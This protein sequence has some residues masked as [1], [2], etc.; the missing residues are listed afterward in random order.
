MIKKAPFARLVREIM[1]DLNKFGTGPDRIQRKAL[2]ML[3][4]G[5]EAHLVA[6]FE[7]L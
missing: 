1:A 7:G 3:Q 2:E 4:V 5:C 6:E